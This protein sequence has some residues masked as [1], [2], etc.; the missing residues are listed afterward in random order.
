MISYVVTYWDFFSHFSKCC[1][2][3]SNRFSQIASQFCRRLLGPWP[4][5]FWMGYRTLKRRRFEPSRSPL[6]KNLTC[7]PFCGKEWTPPALPGYRPEACQFHEWKFTWITGTFSQLKELCDKLWASAF[8][9]ERFM[10]KFYF[11]YLFLINV[12]DNFNFKVIC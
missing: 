11:N 1:F 3:T 8:L 9:Q 4:G 5:F 10:Q 12:C 7:A 6:Q 2:V